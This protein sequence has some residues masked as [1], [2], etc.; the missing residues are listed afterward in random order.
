MVADYGQVGAGA[1]SLLNTYVQGHDLDTKSTRISAGQARR[2]FLGDQVGTVAMTLDDAGAVAE[3]SLRDVWGNLLAGAS[4]ERYGF[5]QRE[6]DSESGLVHVR[7]RMYDSRT[8]RFTQTDPLRGNRPFKPYAYASNNPVSRIDPTGEDDADVARQ[9][10]IATLEKIIK[11]KTQGWGNGL[12]YL[13]T[14]GES[15]DDVAHLQAEV[16]R[17]KGL[18]GRFQEL[19]GGGTGLL[20][21]AITQMSPQAQVHAVVLGRDYVS[22]ERL[23]WGE[24]FLS[25]A[26]YAAGAAGRAA[27]GLRG[28]FRGAKLPRQNVAALVAKQ[29]AK[30]AKAA[31]AVRS[32]PCGVSGPK[33][34]PPLPRM[35][36]RVGAVDDIPGMM[37][38]PGLQSKISK[39]PSPKDMQKWADIYNEEV[40]IYYVRGPGKNGGGGQYWAVVGK[41]GIAE[42][43]VPSSVRDADVMLV[44]HTHP[45]GRNGPSRTDLNYLRGLQEAGSPQLSSKIYVK[46]LQNPVEFDVFTPRAAPVPGGN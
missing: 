27:R 18:E 35:R 5:A 28:A 40:G 10:H 23:S 41:D 37:E 12:K 39:R 21:D 8:G 36:H 24:R 6:H 7:A 43:S 38:F 17:L 33:P 25:A 26:P 1:I 29:E 3:T 9:A 14:F 22:G 30:A 42:F 45:G 16:I 11:E 46:G 15:Y 19:T 44:G 31:R 32:I 4:A 20:M 2:H 34:S 13:V